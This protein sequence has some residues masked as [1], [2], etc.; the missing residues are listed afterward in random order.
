MILVEDQHNKSLGNKKFSLK[1]EKMMSNDTKDL[2]ESS[3]EINYRNIEFWN[4]ETI[5]KREKE[6]QSTIESKFNGVKF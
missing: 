1:K 3:S 4:Q 5:D 6:I 2:F